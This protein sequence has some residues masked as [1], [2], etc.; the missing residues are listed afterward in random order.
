MAMGNSVSIGR[1]HS[2]RIQK[3]IKQISFVIRVPRIL[4]EERTITSVKG[5]LESS[6]QAPMALGNNVILWPWA[7]PENPKDY[8]ML[9]F[10]FNSQGFVIECTLTSLR[11]VW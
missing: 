3:S 6:Y 10:Q 9:N 1:G 2:P 4:C 7:G 8:K 5:A 11:S